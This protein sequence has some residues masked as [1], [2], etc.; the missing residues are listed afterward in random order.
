MKLKSKRWALVGVTGLVAAVLAS[1]VIAAQLESPPDLESLNA[2]TRDAPMTRLADIAAADGKPVRGVFAQITSTGQFCLWDAPSAQS[3]E[4]QGG[5]NPV[6]DPLGGH[7]LSASLAYDGG[8]KAVDVTDAR[9]I[10]VASHEVAA[11]QVLMSDGTRRTMQLRAGTVGSEDY[12][13][14][15]YRFRRADLKGSIGPAAVLAFDEVGREI[16]RQPTGFGR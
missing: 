2:A 4:R 14:F 6:D 8:P 13:A 10:G 12:R 5:C 1:G 15:G 7:A 16:D 9:L 11:I 3:L